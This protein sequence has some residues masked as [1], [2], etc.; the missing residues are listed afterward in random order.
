MLDNLLIAI[1]RDGK[2]EYL[3]EQ[4]SDVNLMIYR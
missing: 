2:N 1:V 4:K 3:S